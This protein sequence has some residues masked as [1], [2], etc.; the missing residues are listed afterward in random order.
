VKVLEILLAKLG[1]REAFHV[2]LTVKEDVALSAIEV[3]PWQ[4]LAAQLVKVPA[5]NIS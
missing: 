3:V 4:V 5:A 1:A 2:D